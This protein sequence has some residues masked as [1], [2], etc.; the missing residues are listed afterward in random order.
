MTIKA[1]VIGVGYLGR[2]HARIYSG[3][4]GV[5]LVG[6]ADCNEEAAREVSKAYNCKAFADYRDLFDSC[7]LFSI[8]TP[9]V[10]H[11]QI[12]LDC[13]RAGKDILVEKPIAETLEEAKDIAEEAE[14][15]QAVV[16]VGHLERYNPAL[17]AALEFIVK[18]QFI[19]SERVSPFLGRGTD[20]D[21]TL[22]LMIHDIDIVIGMVKSKAVDIRAVGSSVITDKLDVAKVWVEFENGCAALLTASRLASEKSRKLRIHQKDSYVFIDYIKQEVTRFFKDESK[23]SREFKK[24]EETEPLLEEIK[25]FLSSVTLR[26]HPKVSAIDGMHALDMALSISKILKGRANHA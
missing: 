3:I 22:D 20:V 16:Q 15:R 6:V 8:V 10:T 21:I 9:T 5:T 4:E 17:L 19:E 2:H 13:L 12:A 14:K 7:D 26:S 1:G 23:I 24:P 25:D 11:H 18:P